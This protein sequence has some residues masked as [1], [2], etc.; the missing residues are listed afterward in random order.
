MFYPAEAQKL[1]PN[2]GY[3]NLF[4]QACGYVRDIANFDIVDDRMVLDG[5]LSNYR[6]LALWEGAMCD[7]ATLDKIRAW[8]NDGGVLLAYDF[9]M[10]TNFEG[11]A[12]WYNDES[13]LF[14]Y[15]KHLNPAQIRE[16]YVG[17]V[18][19]QYRVAV[20][21][22]NTP[23]AADYLADGGDGW[24]APEITDGIARRWTRASASVLL[25]VKAETDYTLIVRA[26]VPPGGAGKKRTV[27]VN[28]Q[29]VGEMGSTG[30]VT[31]R[32]VIPAGVFGNNRLSRLTFQSEPINGPADARPLGLEV[33]YVQLVERG[34]EENAQAPLPP[35][36]IR[37]ELDFGKLKTDWTRKLGKGLTIYFPAN[38]R[39]LKGYIEVLRRAIYR[40]SDIEPGRV[41]ALPIDDAL[42][43]LYTT[44]FTD[45]ILYY[46]SRDKA[47]TKTVHLDPD[48][49]EPWKGQITIPR[50]NTWTITVP[51]HGIEAIRF[52][53]PLEESVFECEEFLQLNNLKPIAAPECSPGTGKTCVVLPKGGEISTTIQLDSP[54]TYSVYTRCTRGGRPEMPEV[55]VDDQVLRP[56][57]TRSG[58]TLLAGVAVLSKGKHTLTLRAHPDRDLRADFI[59][60]TNDPTVSGYDF[61]SKRPAF[62]AISGQ[63]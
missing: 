24:Y 4:A 51:P 49:L 13:E 44:L 36:T 11:D 9:G 61:Y 23:T 5:C 59:I 62:E 14:G 42:D 43:G 53:A 58:Q 39:L 19:P 37:R 20:A 12:P 35:G 7:Q 6:V 55:E 34:E 41:D 22:P 16:R 50:E 31:Y 26:Y 25:P 54:G 52:T 29:I 38:K 57:G 47:V 2:E 46:N 18:P 40:L 33:Q 30:D 56:V 63:K 28:D 48:R 17:T 8:V 15:V 3:D 32:F 60:F 1:R 21:D 10:V 27:S 45:Q